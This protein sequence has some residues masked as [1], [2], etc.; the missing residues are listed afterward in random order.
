MRTQSPKTIAVSV[1]INRI[2][3]NIICLGRVLKPFKVTSH[4]NFEA[5]MLSGPCHVYGVAPTILYMLL[6]INKQGMGKDLMAFL[7]HFWL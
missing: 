6:S 7:F 5:T 1:K 2:L 4:L 3:P